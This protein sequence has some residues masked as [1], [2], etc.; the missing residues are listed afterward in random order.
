[1]IRLHLTERAEESD[2]S[3][4]ERGIQRPAYVFGANRRD[5]YSFTL[6]AVCHR[7]ID[8]RAAHIKHRFLVEAKH[9]LWKL[10]AL[11]V[12]LPAHRSLFLQRS[13]TPFFIFL[14]ANSW[15]V[16]SFASPIPSKHQSGPGAPVPETSAKSLSMDDGARWHDWSFTHPN[17]CAVL[18]AISRKLPRGVE[19]HAGSRHLPGRHE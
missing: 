15:S 1:V 19:T 14:P 17:S 8:W 11:Q 4:A 10:G 2:R 9:E 12:R 7:T 3:R 5:E 18:W 6:N 13:V 16:A